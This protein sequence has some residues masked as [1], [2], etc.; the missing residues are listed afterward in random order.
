M[1]PKTITV[2]ASSS[3]DTASGALAGT[4]KTS[5]GTVAGAVI[6]TLIA[7]GVFGAG[8]F[9]WWRRRQNA[10]R[11]QYPRRQD[12]EYTS[13]YGGTAPPMESVDVPPVTIPIPV[14][15]T[16]RVRLAPNEPFDPHVAEDT[17]SPSASS[18]SSSTIPPVS[19]QILSAMRAV[20]VNSRPM[21][22]VKGRMS[23]TSNSSNPRLP[24]HP[25]MRLA[26]GTSS[27][28]SSTLSSTASSSKD[29]PGG[30]SDT[31]G[32]PGD[33]SRSGVTSPST[34]STNQLLH[35]VVGLRR[36]MEELRQQRLEPPPSYGD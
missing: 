28:S 10:Q 13:G 4:K 23:A 25:A 32:G 12:V 9:Y 8:G 20:N 26:R 27:A 17:L 5:G 22:D 18:S 15:R 29:T 7:V 35:E 34:E 16:R 24:S 30:N 19:E 2:T 11:Q 3:G 36:E 33:G 14:A 31:S 21:G 6:G 1:A